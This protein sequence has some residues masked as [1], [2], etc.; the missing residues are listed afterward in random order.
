[1]VTNAAAH[2]PA[3]RIP[4][5]SVGMPVYNSAAWIGQSIESILQQS[6]RDLELIVSDNA[7]TDHTF[8]ICEEYARADA[9]VRLLRNPVNLG[10]NRN[11]LAVLH[12]ARGRYFKWASSNDVCAP[13]FIET[14][15]A[16]LEADASAVLACPKSYIFE[17]S[18]EAAQPYDRDL[19]L[20]A[21]DPAERFVALGS[22]MGLNNAF[23]GLIRRDALLRVS[24]MGS[25]IGAD[26][27]LMGELALLGKFLLVDE[28]LFYRRMS[29]ESATKLKSSE[30][31]ER[32]LAPSAR[33]PLKWQSWRFHLALLRATRL[34]GFP[35]RTW[36]Q[37]V[38]HSL[39]SFVWARRDLASEVLRTLR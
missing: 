18:I 22:R 13:A 19:A 37:A 39:R 38:S 3:Q 11:Y 31:V 12:A 1:M 8:Q 4:S 35:S 16:R 32:H 15:L 10:A 26:V 34:A 30:E 29:P 2:E 5:V 28:R 33:G 9:R 7:S 21:D 6:H 25:Y 20:L 17:R 14:C 27:V 36:L 24:A 23:N